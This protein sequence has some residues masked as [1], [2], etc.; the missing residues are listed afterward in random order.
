MHYA[1]PVSRTAQAVLA[2]TLLAILTAWATDTHQI[3][4]S[5]RIDKNGTLY[6]ITGSGEEIRAPKSKGAVG[7][8]E[9]KVS[10]D[11]RRVGW[12]ALYPFPGLTRGDYDPG[13]Y[14]GS[15][16]IYAGGKVVQRF[17]TDQMFWDWHFWNGGAQVAFTTG[18]WHG[19]AAQA[20]L[21]DI[22]TGKTIATWI[23]DDG[24]PP[25]WAKG[26]RH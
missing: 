9:A 12:L 25:E 16:V 22:V 1:G 7:S 26:L 5:I 6:I 4:R 3:Y 17:E 18:P 19:G 21:C 2:V 8:D 23:P 11:G 13:P 10:S 24:E 14:E 15:L 20:R